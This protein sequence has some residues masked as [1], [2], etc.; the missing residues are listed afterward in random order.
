MEHH[1]VLRFIIDLEKEIIKHISLLDRN[2]EK[3]IEY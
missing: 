2:T 1:G 3:L